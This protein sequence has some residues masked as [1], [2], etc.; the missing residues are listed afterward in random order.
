[1]PEFIEEGVN[2]FMVDR[3][4]RKYANKL[5]WMKSHQ[6]QTFEMGQKA[7]VEIMNNWTWEKVVKANERE[8]FR[9]ILC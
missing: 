2:G 8:A 4:V 3:D 9:R 5:R 7:R 6:Q 1:M